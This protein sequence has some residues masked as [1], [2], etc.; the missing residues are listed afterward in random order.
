MGRAHVQR[1]NEA[2]CSAGQAR[3]QPEEDAEARVGVAVA[4][5]LGQREP[6]LER[7]GEQLRQRQPQ[8]RAH[9][10]ALEG[11]VLRLPRAP[12]RPLQ[13]LARRHRAP[14]G[15]LPPFSR[16][17]FAAACGP[18]AA[19]P[20]GR[21]PPSRDFARVDA[22]CCTDGTTCSVALLRGGLSGGRMRGTLYEM[23]RMYLFFLFKLFLSFIY[24]GPEP[25]DQNKYY[26]SINVFIYL[27]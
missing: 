8:P 2:V 12:H 11:L 4:G 13:L 9:A 17:L 22:A 10:A 14:A 1:S 19:R 16:L 27:F 20:A 21:A 15:Q 7:R 25:F 24:C 23:E 5:P 3:P 18:E 26:L 6:G